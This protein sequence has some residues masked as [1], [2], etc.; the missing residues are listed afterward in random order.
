MY[1]CQFNEHFLH[2]YPN[3]YLRRDSYAE[4]L[5]NSPCLTQNMKNDVRS[6]LVSKMKLASLRKLQHR[7]HG[8]LQTLRVVICCSLRE[9]L[10]PFRLYSLCVVLC[11]L[12][13]ACILT[14]LHSS[15]LDAPYLLCTKQMG[16]DKTKPYVYVGY[17]GV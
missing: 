13:L 2:F 10:Y 17:N 7:K 9:V 3:R 16:M 1:L 12:M 5:K 14:H 15:F 8:S 6:R 11:S 4:L